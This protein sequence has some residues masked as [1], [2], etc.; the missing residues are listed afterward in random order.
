MMS[1][2]L[3]WNVYNLPNVFVTSCKD[4]EYSKPV[5]ILT[6]NAEVD[7]A[8]LRKL[9]ESKVEAPEDAFL[10]GS[11]TNSDQYEN[12]DVIAWAEL[13]NKTSDEFDE[14]VIEARV[15]L[16]KIIE[17]YGISLL[18]HLFIKQDLMS[19]FSTESWSFDHVD[20]W[21][22]LEDYDGNSYDVN[23]LSDGGSQPTMKVVCYRTYEE[24]GER[25]RNLTKGFFTIFEGLPIER[26]KKEI[27]V[28]VCF[29]VTSKVKVLVDDDLDDKQLKKMVNELACEKIMSTESGYVS[30]S[31]QVLRYD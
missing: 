29:E 9:P 5:M 12:E 18:N 1:L 14:L 4:S 6:A 7:I 21:I 10:W 3:N 8:V 25:I 24:N 2:V 19:F 26:V 30:G 23:F 15:N 11:C 22:Q 20:V 27:E 13:T 28:D 17:Q 31:F 16:Q